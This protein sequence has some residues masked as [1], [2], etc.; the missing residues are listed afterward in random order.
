MKAITK[1]KQNN[2]WIMSDEGYSYIKYISN[3]EHL[4]RDDRVD[5][6]E[7]WFANK[8]HASYGLIYKNTHLEF[9]RS[10]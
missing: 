1:Q 3:G 5:S 8:N 2:K 10:A 7:I 9:A 6:L 4:L